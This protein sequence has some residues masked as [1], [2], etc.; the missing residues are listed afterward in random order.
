MKIH[1]GQK[2]VMMQWRQWLGESFL[3][4]VV[5]TCHEEEEGNNIIQMYIYILIEKIDVMIDRN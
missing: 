3:T 2:K 5:C 4:T 1:Q